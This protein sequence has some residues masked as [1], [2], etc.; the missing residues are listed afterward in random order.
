MKQ[1]N[2]LFEYVGFWY[3]STA[4]T[5]QKLVIC[6]SDFGVYAPNPKPLKYLNWGSG[7]CG[8]GRRGLENFKGGRWFLDV[9][10]R[11]L[12]SKPHFKGLGFRVLPTPYREE[13]SSEQ[14]RQLESQMREDLE[15]FSE[16]WVP[17]LGSGFTEGL[18]RD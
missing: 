17:F 16:L 8:L 5:C 9:L 15:G 10:P 11:T 4:R 3:G 13:N 14:V 6:Y 1:R 18:E 7:F 2:P 12:N